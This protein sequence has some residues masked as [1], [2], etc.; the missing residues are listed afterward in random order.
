MISLFHDKKIDDF[1]D[2]IEKSQSVETDL[3]WS[4]EAQILLVKT[5][6]NF[7]SHIETHFGKNIAFS[8][9]YLNIFNSRVK[10]SVKPKLQQ[11]MNVQYLNLEKSPSG[12]P[13][14]H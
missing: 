14:K 2:A 5:F 6:L 3:Q 1:C 12:N 9:G 4:I 13:S 11:L 7:R 10:I 8:Q